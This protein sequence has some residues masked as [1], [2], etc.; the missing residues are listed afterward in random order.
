MRATGSKHPSDHDVESVSADG[1]KI[2]KVLCYD[3]TSWVQENSKPRIELFNEK[4]E[5]LDIVMDYTQDRLS[6]AT[7]KFAA[8]YDAVCLFV[9]DV[10]DSETIWTLSMS[11]VRLIDHRMSVVFV[12]SISPL[13]RITV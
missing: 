3:A 8:G 9:N 5:G 7:A 11:G 10:A 2:L 1:K 4:N 13:T 6:K 12:S